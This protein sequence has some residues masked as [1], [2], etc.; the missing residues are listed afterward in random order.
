MKLRVLLL[1]L[2]AIGDFVLFTGVLPYVRKH[3]QNNAITLVVDPIVA[4]L[5][6]GCPYVDEIIT[7]DQQRYATEKHYAGEIARK[8]RGKFEVAINVMYTRTW[9][10][11][12]IIARTH[13]PVKIGFQ[14]LDQD[15][16]QERRLTE[17]VLYTHL[18]QTTNEWMFELDRY[19]QFLIGIGAPVSEQSM[20]PE[21]W[22]SEKDNQW[23]KD[24]VEAKFAATGKFA[25][26]CP[27][28]GF[29]S[30]L[31]SS[32]S[33]ARIADYLIEDLSLPVVIAGSEKD[34]ELAS[35]II[36]NTK[37]RIHGLTGKINLNQFA[38]LVK[39]SSIYVG[40]DTAGFHIAWALGIP[41][42]GIFGGGHF[43][44]FTPSLPH[45]QI[46]HHAMDC[47]NCYWHCIYD[48]TKCIS[49][50]TPEKVIHAIE[51]LMQKSDNV[52]KG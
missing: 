10:S 49:S 33:F 16:Q 4:P 25:V 51:Q 44:R 37:N 42:I 15:G 26:L 20:K 50:V 7:I 9:Q 45:V 46:V 47:Y 39:Q 23:A 3:F 35:G 31:W 13:A 17:Q 19:K 28:A 2:D 30:K 27:G 41:T 32:G 18:V 24:F 22:I 52:A 21:L 34:K 8:V 38:A 48:E 12:N 1:R 11:D 29:D 40:I 36:V 43:G 5:A 14:C 6:E